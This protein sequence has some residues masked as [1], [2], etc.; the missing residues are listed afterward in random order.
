MSERLLAAF[1]DPEELDVSPGVALLEE[2]GLRVSVLDTRDPGRIVAEAGDAAALLIG[3]T[4]VDGALMDA[5]PQLRLVAA[6]AVG[7]DSVDLAAASSRGIQ[8]CNVPDA[9]TEEVAVHALALA[10][11]LVRRLPMLDRLVR[12]GGW[13][14]DATEQMRRP[15]SMTLGILGLG[16]IGRYLA[17][18]AQPVFGTVVGH[19]PALSEDSWPSGVKRRS[20]AEVLACSDVLSLHLPASPGSRPLIGEEAIG[21][22]KAGA[23]LVNVS[24]GSL[25]DESALLSALEDGR[26]AGAGLDVLATEPPAAKDPLRAHP[27]A[28]VTPHLAYLSDESSLAYALRAAENVVAWATTGRPRNPVD[29]RAGTGGPSKERAEEVEQWGS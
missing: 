17:R 9:A 21:Q 11:C 20:F 5:L 4:R 29:T 25:V 14:T 12:A 23:L 7:V 26:L 22:L 1:T 18:I 10:L 19:D 2:A 27:R 16:R 13:S 15:S 6:M 3:Y 24:R 28:V 8:V